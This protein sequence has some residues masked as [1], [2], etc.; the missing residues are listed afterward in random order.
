MAYDDYSPAFALDSN[1]ARRARG[2]RFRHFQTVDVPR[3]RQIGLALNA[4]GVLLH[5]YLVYGHVSLHDGLFITSVLIG[6][7]AFAWLTIRLLWQR[8]RWFDV[9]DLFLVIDVV[10]LA[11]V[12][13]VSGANQSFLWPVFL[14]RPADQ[15]ATTFKRAVFFAHL[16]PLAFFGLMAYITGVE[17]RQIDWSVEAAKGVFLYFMAIYIALTARTAEARRNKL[18]DAR[19]IAEQAVRDADLQRRELERALSKLENASK[20]KSEFLAN[21]SH[22][23]RTPLNSVLGSSD[24]LLDSPL[25]REQREM[26]GVLRD[27]AESLTHIVNDI[28][29]LARVEARRMP[30]EQIPMRLRDVAGATLRMFTARAHQ[31]PIDL[32]CHVDRDVPEALTGD[33][34]RLRQVLTNL[35]GNAVKFTERGE[36][37]LRVEREE[38]RGGRLALRFSVRDTGIGIPKDRQAAIFEAFTQVDGSSTRKYGGTGLGLT[39]ANE[40]VGLMD[41]RLWVDSEPGR[42]STFSFIAWFGRASTDAPL[43][44]AAGG[45]P[46]GTR[47]LRVLIAD[48]HLEAQSALEEALSIWPTDIRT[49]SGAHAALAAADVAQAA[50]A[51][52]ELAFIDADLP[53]IDALELAARLRAAPFR[54]PHVVLLVGSRDSAVGAERAL[55]LG[56]LYLVK[57]VTQQPL[58]ELLRG[59]FGG[60]V[61]HASRLTHMRPPVRP[62][63]VLVADDHEVNQAVVAAVLKKWGHAVASA[64]DGQEVLDRLAGEEYDLVLMDLQMPV[65]DGLDATRRLRQREAATGSPRVKVIAMTA[66][67]LDEDRE[68]CLAAGMDGYLSKPLDQHALFEVLVAVGGVAPGASVPPP[69]PS[70]ITAVISDPALVR[71]VAGLFLSTA[72]EQLARL[73]RAL[74]LGDAPQ[75]RAVAH[76]LKG[77]AQYFAGAETTAAVEI[78]QLCADGHVERALSRLD[79]LR[80]DIDAISARLRV[81]LQ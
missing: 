8:V 50:G 81:F 24:L 21:V 9:G 45:A 74:E 77:A 79:Q 31:R 22:E 61:Q 25:T 58:A 51:P 62:L 40:L 70:S 67:A 43:A 12:V 46:W 66:R 42:G 5:N 55:A 76:S 28:L 20:A 38:E 56:A 34:I 23:L 11:F 13:Y 32:V 37:V 68:R 10:A 44:D 1:A 26:V 59:A 35:I 19:R 2:Q 30:L 75:A 73:T 27:S 71:H 47:T 17:H 14:A 29:D 49:S 54:V 18:A 53:G 36:I 6:Y 78:E 69:D 15:V 72:P 57:P 64:L 33:P 80:A 16:G 63:R 7:A 3:L 41:G 65:M 48:G 60:D 4:I 39:I 52:L